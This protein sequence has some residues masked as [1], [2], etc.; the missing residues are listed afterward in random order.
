M[1][2]QETVK[3]IMEKKS[4]PEKSADSPATKVSFVHSAGETKHTS[5]TGL[6]GSTQG[7]PSEEE[8]KSTF[9]SN[10]KTKETERP[11]D[12]VMP[13]KKAGKIRKQDSKVSIDS[14]TDA[15]IDYLSPNP[16]KQAADG[17]KKTT[18]LTR[19]DYESEEDQEV[20][21]ESEEV[22]EEEISIGHHLEALFN[23]Q[24]LTEDFKERVSVVF[25]AAVSERVNY[26]SKKLQETVESKLSAS[27][28]E[29]KKEM[30]ENLDSYLSYVTEEWMKENEV[31]IEKGLRNEITEEF[32]AGL[33]NLFVEHNIDVP[34]SKVD[35]LEKM[36][37]RI[38]EL[39][40]SLNKEISNNI[41]LKEQLSRSSK[42]DVVEE[43]GTGLTVSEKIKLRK[44]LE[45]VSY[46]SQE[47]LLQKATILK[48]NY[49]TETVQSID[50]EENIEELQSNY[51]SESTGVMDQY[52][53]AL[54]KLSSKK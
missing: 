41:Q 6:A 19:E 25:E 30:A 5:S 51:L 9:H 40:E 50:T 44:L 34:E 36:A 7:M 45:G 47:D 14:E 8:G 23:G 37:D 13:G 35:V 22:V 16:G 38:E 29:N 27:I 53:K 17:I 49:F 43:I 10:V 20:V 15:E 32:L 3:K 46:V 12:D 11:S 52:L 1:D 31:A 39:E 18:K 54:S 48:E 33:R 4:G 2:I 24:D 28:E 42:R 21:S 26:I